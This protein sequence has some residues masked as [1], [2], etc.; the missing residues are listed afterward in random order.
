MEFPVEVPALEDT[1][2]GPMF[3][4]W[5]TAPGYLFSLAERHNGGGNIG[6][7]D[8]H[9]HWMGIDQWVTKM[10]EG[11]GDLKVGN[12]APVAWLAPWLEWYVAP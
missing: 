2:Y 6:Y 9:A 7:C 10:A 3:T 12:W 11:D 4:F 1:N 8:G 5:A